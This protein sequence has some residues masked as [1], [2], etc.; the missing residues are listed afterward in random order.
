MLTNNRSIRQRRRRRRQSVIDDD[1]DDYAAMEEGRD[2][3]LSFAKMFFAMLYSIL[4]LYIP[5]LLF[6]YGTKGKELKRDR[7]P[8]EEKIDAKLSDN[9][10]RRIYRM[11]R[12]SFYKL[13]EMLE[14]KLNEIFFPKGGGKRKPGKC[15]YLIDTKTRL[16]IALRFFAGADPVDLMQIHDVGLVSVYYS[17]WCVIDAI[18]QTDELKYS[19]PAEAEQEVIAAG[20]KRKSGA[21]FSNVIG[22][23][24]GLVICTLM[25]SLIICRMLNC[26]QKSFRCHR[27]DKFGLNMQ[28]ICDHML[29]FTWVEIKWP[30][31]TSDYLAWVTSSLCM[32]LEEGTGTVVIK[33]GF[34]LV[35]DN[36]YVK[37]PY[38]ATPL[39][40]IRAGYED[41][42]NFYLSQLRITIERAFGVL[43]HR[44]S[45][46]RAPLTI[47]I[48]KVAPMMESLIRLH[49]YCINESEDTIVAIQD[50][51]SRNLHRN[52]RISRELGGSDSCLVDFDDVGRPTS[53]LNHGHHFLDA[54]SY[55]YDRSLA[56]TRTPM[57]EMID[58]VANQ[59]LTRPRYD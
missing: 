30:A 28:A 44:W 34:T 45:I 51:N 16:S 49:N 35:G 33:P 57:D 7:R 47:P 43:V 26:G 21:G 15:S 11:S 32:M 52:V 10:F 27:K 18:N 41:G 50:R 42:Y 13:H 29:R 4:L 58:S 2:V 19:F 12:Q 24:D 22:A 53:L 5:S 9:L 40:G 55:R 17:V 46:L 56:R 3:E 1:D 20:F 23:I 38:M 48:P 37:K 54:E 36:A 8:F 14:P 25:P 6:E 59:R 31:A 39:K